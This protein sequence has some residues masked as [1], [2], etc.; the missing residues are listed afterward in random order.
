M[1]YYEREGQS[2]IRVPLDLKWQIIAELEGDYR[3][4]PFGDLRAVFKEMAARHWGL[5]YAGSP[6]ILDPSLSDCMIL[7]VLSGVA[8]KRRGR[9]P[10]SFSRALL[11]V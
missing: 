3:D 5:S 4:S 11:E 10:V 9:P 1:G 6:L 7:D 2:R 8:K